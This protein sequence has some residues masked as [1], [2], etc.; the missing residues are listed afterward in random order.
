MLPREVELVPKWSVKCFWVVQWTG[1]CAILNI[2]LPCNMF[3]TILRGNHAET[4]S[5]LTCGPACLPWEGSRYRR[6]GECWKTMDPV[7]S[8][9]RQWEQAMVRI[10]TPC[11]TLS[12]PKL[13][14]PLGHHWWLLPQSLLVLRQSNFVGKSIP[15]SRFE[16]VAVWYWLFT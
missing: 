2:P 12:I 16:A 10:V 14:K 1:Y 9:A 4:S 13:S 7:L 6:S 15:V 11:L 8:S 3:Q 5:S